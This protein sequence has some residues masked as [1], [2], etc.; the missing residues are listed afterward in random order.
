MRL[1]IISTFLLIAV[2]CILSSPVEESSKK[3]LV[4]VGNP[5]EGSKGKS[6]SEPV[7]VENVASNW[8]CTLNDCVNLCYRFLNPPFWAWCSNN[9]CWCQK[10]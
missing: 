9:T 5:E 7:A 2:T 4:K 6:L 10:A 8:V 3:V 1:I